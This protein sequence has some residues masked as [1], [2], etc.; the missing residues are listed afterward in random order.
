MRAGKRTPREHRGLHILWTS[1]YLSPTPCLLWMLL[2]VLKIL[3]PRVM[4]LSPVSAPNPATEIRFAIPLLTVPLGQRPDG[5]RL[6]PHP[7]TGHIWGLGSRH[8]R[9]D[10]LGSGGSPSTAAPHSAT[11][12][13]HLTRGRASPPSSRLSR[14]PLPGLGL[15]GQ[16]PP[17]ARCFQEGGGMQTHRS[18]VSK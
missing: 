7:C 8:N 16:T 18:G 1:R 3:V 12:P 5:S 4:H 6:A 9:S 10:K 14:Q 11:A 13:E 15:R 2:W 17:N